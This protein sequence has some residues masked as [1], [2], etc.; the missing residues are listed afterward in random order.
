[1]NEGVSQIA[2]SAGHGIDPATGLIGSTTASD[3]VGAWG[4][5]LGAVTQHI[6][7]VVVL[8][9]AFALFFGTLCWYLRAEDKR[10]GYPMEDP[11]QPPRAH[12][13]VGFPP[14]PAPKTFTLQKGGTVT[15]PNFISPPEVPARHLHPFPG[16]AFVP[17]GANPMR[18]PIG[19]AS[20]VLRDE[21]PLLMEGEKLQLVPLRKVGDAWHV[22]GGDSDPVGMPVVGRDDK[23]A[24]HVRDLWVDRGAKLLR[25]LEVELNDGRRRLMPVFFANVS[26]KFRR[27]KTRS[28]FAEQFAAIPELKDPDR[29]TAREEDRISA[30]FAGGK[31]FAE[32]VRRGAFGGGADARDGLGRRP[33]V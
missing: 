15:L 30:Y 4:F 21:E 27:V 9:W 22:Q 3:A 11:T 13:L 7:G 14:P 8:F 25:Y 1:M 10:E 28:I 5:H 18:D 24:G 2:G 6:D 16:S 33:R 26:P 23:V 17:T 29:I 19:P 12:P 32:G 31:M 20:W